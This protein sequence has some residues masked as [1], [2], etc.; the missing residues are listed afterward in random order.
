M[1]ETDIL[2]ALQDAGK[3]AVAASA[4]PTMPIKAIGRTFIPANDAPDGKYVEFVN[5][6]NNRNGDYW[7]DSRVYQGNFRII[8]HWPNDDAG[9][10]PGSGYLDQLAAFFPKGKVFESGQAIVRI[11]DV[12]N[13][14]GMITNGAELLY[15]VAFPYR[16]FKS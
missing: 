2:T 8:L 11:Y 13:A 7:D 5:I 10:Y 1:I 15:P 3:A 4:I 6:V 12:P 14:S 9:T 16:C